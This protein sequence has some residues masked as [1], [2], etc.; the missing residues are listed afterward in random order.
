VRGS[1]KGLLMPISDENRTLT[2]FQLRCEKK[3]QQALQNLGKPISNRRLNGET[4]TY[5]TGVIE[6]TITFWI[7]LDGADWEYS[8]RHRVFERPDYP[9]L[10]ELSDTS[11]S[12]A[13]LLPLKLSL[14]GF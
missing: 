10:D 14:H 8:G 7:Y 4:E 5:I 3:L 13:I 1:K 12:A 11:R 9:S 2:E 6:N